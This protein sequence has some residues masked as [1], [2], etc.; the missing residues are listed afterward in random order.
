MILRLPNSILD[1]QVESKLI[2][3]NTQ[4]SCIV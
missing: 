4:I 3:L 2:F 1:E